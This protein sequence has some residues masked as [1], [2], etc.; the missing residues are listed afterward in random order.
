MLEE[1]IR[2]EHQRR[3]ARQLFGA[4]AIREMPFDKRRAGQ[5]A[6][7]HRPQQ[8]AARARNRT[9]TGAKARG[10]FT[11][12]HAFEADGLVFDNQI[13]QQMLFGAKI[14]HRFGPPRGEAVGIKSDAQTFRQTLLVQRGHKGL[15]VTLK[16]THLLHMVEQTPAYL[17]RRRW[18]AANQHRLA[19]P[20]FEQFDPLRNRR[21]RQTQHLRGPFESGLL[22]HGG[23]SRKQFVVE[24]QFS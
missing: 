1:I 13:E 23:Q 7:T 22:D 18:R 14:S 9:L 5:R 4:Y 15:Q 21:L 20:R 17:G 16:Q 19:D 12:A 2:A 24:H 6:I 11:G 3:G 8:H 10:H